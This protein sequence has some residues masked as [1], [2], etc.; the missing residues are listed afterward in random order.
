MAIK[1]QPNASKIDKKI[2]DENLENISGGAWIGDNGAYH[3]AGSPA[4]GTYVEPSTATTTT[5][6]TKKSKK[7]S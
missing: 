2:S 5:P 4:G 7:K 6:K 1:Q 3:G